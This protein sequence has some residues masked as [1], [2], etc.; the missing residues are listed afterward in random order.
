MTF[1]DGIDGSLEVEAAEVVSFN[2]FCVGYLSTPT[3]SSPGALKTDTKEYDSHNIP[4]TV[5]MVL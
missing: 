4:L 3:P 5:I 1:T 2:S